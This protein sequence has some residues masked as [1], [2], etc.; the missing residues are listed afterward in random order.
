MTKSVVG[1]LNAHGGMGGRKIQLVQYDVD[2]TA[3]VANAN[4]AM[5]AACTYFTQDQK[6]VAVTSIVALLPE[7][8]YTCMADAHVP[9]VSADESVSRDFFQRFPSAL[10]MPAVPNYTRLMND[11][12]EALW[13]AGW[14]TSTSVVGVVAVDTSDAHSVVDKGLIPALQRHG[15]K[16]ETGLY[17]STDQSQANAYSAGVLDFNSRHVDRVFF[18]PGGQPIYFATAAESQAYHPKYELGSLEYPGT[19]AI[20]LPADQLSGSMG[21]GWLPYI[22]LPPSAWASVPTSG[23]ADCLKALRSSAQDFSTGTTLAIGAWICDD[24]NF[25]RDAFKAGASPDEAGIRR[26]A[27]SLGDTFR[28][29]ATFQSTSAPGRTHDGASAYRL[30]AFHDACTCYRYTTPQKPMS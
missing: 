18:A 3:F 24:W 16:L 17:T 4:T 13:S 6:V 27:E 19:L 26:A 25:L 20:D 7:S 5:A 1:Y 2:A 11:S 23:I 30:L 15:L 14:L 29:A 12:V 28:A 8:F 9:V 21:L 10:Y 22:D